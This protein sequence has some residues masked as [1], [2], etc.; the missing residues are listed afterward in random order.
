MAVDNPTT[1]TPPISSATPTAADTEAVKNYAAANNDA[2]DA[3]VRTTGATGPAAVALKGALDLMGKFGLSVSQSSSILEAFDN[4]LDQSRNVLAL[5]SGDLT[6]GTGA[7]QS[8]NNY[9]HEHMAELQN[10]TDLSSQ[11]MARFGLEATAAFGA[12][13]SSFGSANFSHINLFGDQLEDL[14]KPIEADSSALGTLAA[15]MGIHIPASIVGMAA[16]MAK[17]IKDMATSSDNAIKLEDVMVRAAAATGRLGAVHDW[18]GKSLENINKLVDDQRAAISNTIVATNL[19]KDV[20]ESYY[21]QLQKL[22]TAYKANASEEEKARGNVSQLT[23]VIMLAR[24]NGREYADV[25]ND[26]HEA[27]RNYNAS[28]P[29]AMRFTQQISEV[30]QNT[31]ADLRDVQQALIGTAAAFKYFGGEGSDAASVVNKYAQA[32]RATTGVSADVSIEIGSNMVNSLSK[33]TLAQKAFLS[34]QQ[35]GAGGF[36]GAFAIDMKLR[37]GKY[38]E[39]S[40]MLGDQLKKMMGGNLV[41]LEEASKSPAAQAQMMKQVTML[42]SG[43]LAVARNDQEA[44]DI[45]D[46]LAK[47]GTIDIKALKEKDMGVQDSI[48]KGNLYAAQTVTG[49]SETNALLEKIRGAISGADRNVVQA[50]MTEGAGFTYSGQ[51]AEEIQNARRE[52]NE[53]RMA[54]ARN[55]SKPANT[56]D[57]FR[58]DLPKMLSNIP[59]YLGSIMKG[60]GSLTGN[61]KQT[62]G[63]IVLDQFADEAKRKK[64]DAMANIKNE[65]DRK[66]ELARIDK[67]LAARNAELAK[68][69]GVVR[70]ASGN[71]TVLPTALIPPPTEQPTGATKLPAITP[72]DTSKALR[73]ARTLPTS[74][75]AATAATLAAKNASAATSQSAALLPANNPAQGQPGAV[76]GQ[77]AVTVNIHCA[78]CG[79]LVETSDQMQSVISAPTGQQGAGHDHVRP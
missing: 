56:A 46:M 10:V 78:K 69:T 65:V 32:L 16:P 37:A 21:E 63:Q 12:T 61:E 35:G 9:I 22:P 8:F 31:G 59:V 30:T 75:L 43:P 47:G 33:M 42:K 26:M 18:A 66:K 40:K 19:S 49:I 1:P 39:V 54:G 67:E 45:S 68:Q 14:I 27:M 24:G 3:I 17:F 73:P 23:D 2:T 48:A 34:T 6:K 58:E 15:K 4:R 28:M 44:E 7:F 77:M 60:I 50:G 79:A 13:K 55:V 72:T 11:S 36:M 51:E 29:E 41:T 62:E 74:D 20:V 53:T 70:G 25:I 5:L 71:V 57:I 64:E 52:L 38:E 76:L